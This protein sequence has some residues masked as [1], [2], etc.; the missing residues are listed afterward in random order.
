MKQRWM[1]CAVCLQ[2]VAGDAAAAGMDC[3]RAAST[4]EKAICSQPDLQQMD[5]RLASLY[6]LSL[7]AQPAERSSLRKAQQDWLKERDRCGAEPTCLRARYQERKI[8]LQNR[9]RDLFF[10]GA[11]DETDRLA[12]KD[13]AQKVE[14]RIKSDPEFPLESV[15]GELANASLN[16]QGTHFENVNNDPEDPDIAHFPKEQPKGVSNDEWRAL[17]ASGI[18]VGG[19]RGRANYTL[20]DFDQDGKRD[21]LIDSYEGGTGLWSYVSVMR[22]VGERFISTPNLERGDDPSEGGLYSINGRGANQNATWIQLRG[23]TYV[24]YVDSY[25]GVDNVSLI[26]PLVAMDLPALAVHYRYRFTVPPVQ[27]RDDEAGKPAEVKLDAALQKTLLKALEPLSV[28]TNN[29]GNPKTPLCPASV[30]AGEEASNYGPGHYSFEIVHDMEIWINKKCHI[31]R[32][33][34]WF[35]S[36]SREHGLFASLD[37]REPGD[38]EGNGIGFEIK[39]KRTAI[40]VDISDAKAGK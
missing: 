10:T 19:E 4:T 35:G 6:G 20:Y 17:Q 2:L 29:G 32:L 36:Y 34:N 25:Y 38:E 7:G 31:S 8:V 16:S 30:P 39:G 5:A 18:D 23:R 33:S 14:A 15:L 3:T 22:R 24:A 13:L 40:R 1:F 21:L 37:L 27:S 9:M 28:E 11:S 12:L 26:R